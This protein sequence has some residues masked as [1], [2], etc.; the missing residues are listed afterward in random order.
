MGKLNPKYR[1][2]TEAANPQKLLAVSLPD[3]QPLQSEGTRRPLLNLNHSNRAPVAGP[4]RTQDRLQQTQI[5]V[6]FMPGMPGVLASGDLARD[7]ILREPG[8]QKAQS[9]QKSS[10]A[11]VKSSNIDTE[12]VLKVFFVLGHGSRRKTKPCWRPNSRPN[13][14]SSSHPPSH[15]VQIVVDP[16]WQEQVDRARAM[17]SSSRRLDGTAPEESV[18]AD[19]EGGNRPVSFCSLE[20][21]H[22]DLESRKDR[23]RKALLGLRPGVKTG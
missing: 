10:T 6:L 1:T 15:R 19:R 17:K 18:P 23:I 13:P 8:P 16:D 14:G 7:A 5:E 11:E 9:G 21:S 20:G 3:E 4:A 12:S 22:F 2:R